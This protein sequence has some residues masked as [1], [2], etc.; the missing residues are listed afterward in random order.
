[1]KSPKLTKTLWGIT[2]SFFFLGDDMYISFCAKIKEKDQ[3]LDHVVICGYSQAGYRITNNK[4]GAQIRINGKSKKNEH[5]T[6]EHGVNEHGIVTNVKNLARM[7]TYSENF[8]DDRGAKWHQF[9]EAS[10]LLKVVCK[11]NNLWDGKARVHFK[12]SDVVGDPKP[13]GDDPDIVIPDPE[14]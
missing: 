12:I 5:G 3:H 7:A 2:Y 10:Q 14:K 1:M 6:D 8:K 4:A 11:F 9:T 13:E